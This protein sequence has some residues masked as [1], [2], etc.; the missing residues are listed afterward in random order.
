[1]ADWPLLSLLIWVPIIGG[2]I[3][4]A[5]ADEQWT[6][7]TRSLSL[8]TALLTLALCIP[9]YL[10]FDST[11]AEMQ[12]VEFKDWIVPF[13]IN[14]SLGI[15]G[16]S[17]PLIIL[18]CFATMIVIVTSWQSVQS[19]VAQYMASFLILSGFIN[20]V[21]VA[22]DGILFYVFWEAMLVPMFLIIGIW[23]GQNR[24]YATVKFFLYTFLGSVFMLIALIYLYL[25]SG[26]FSILEFH[27]LPIALNVQILLFIA[28]LLAFAVKVPMWPVHTWLPDAHTEAPTGGSIILAAVLLKV[29]AYGFL[30]FSLPI[31]PDASAYLAG[32]MIALSA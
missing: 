19:R 15:D 20:G 23:G 6:G 32:V 10:N 24:V 31:V 21:F 3:V 9:L 16:I 4:L 30:R 28:F 25:Q 2:S 17:L 13:D 27:A 12:F 14:Y 18:N 11:T 26:S 1:M 5:S 22:L 29:G 8:L 7:R